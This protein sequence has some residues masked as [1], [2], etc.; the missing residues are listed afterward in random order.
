MRQSRRGG[1]NYNTWQ[2]IAMPPS[3][4]A[5]CVATDDL[6]EKDAGYGTVVSV[7]EA[8]LAE[9]FTLVGTDTRQLIAIEFFRAGVIKLFV[10]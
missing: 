2:L 1:D 9:S 7:L 4:C 5:N 10:R 6:I 8:N 3:F